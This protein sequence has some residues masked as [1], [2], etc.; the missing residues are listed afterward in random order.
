LRVSNPEPPRSSNF[1]DGFEKN[2]DG[3]S[4]GERV[5]I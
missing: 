1:P 4:L 5:T 2:G 3:E